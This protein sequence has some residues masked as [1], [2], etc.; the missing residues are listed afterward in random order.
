MFILES[1]ATTGNMNIVVGSGMVPHS[2]R[3]VSQTTKP[4]K[5]VFRITSS[6]VTNETAASQHIVTETDEEFRK[7]MESMRELGAIE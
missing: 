2:V 5:K 6:S 3:A 1:A 4:K 7:Y